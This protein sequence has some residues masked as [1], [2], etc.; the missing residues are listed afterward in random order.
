M[1]GMSFQVD[2]GSAED[3]VKA[4]KIIEALKAKYPDEPELRTLHTIHRRIAAGAKLTPI[5]K[6][7][8]R[9]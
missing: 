7:G 9:S 1:F 8:K 4:D 3:L 2:P 6:D 5:E